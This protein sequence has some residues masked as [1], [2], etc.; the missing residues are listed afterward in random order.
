M[1]PI[2]EY[3]QLF[4]WF[5]AVLL[6]WGYVSCTICLGLLMLCVLSWHY[7]RVY[8]LR[9]KHVHMVKEMKDRYN[10]E[11]EQVK[12]RQAGLDMYDLMGYNLAEALVVQ[13]EIELKP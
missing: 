5:G 9:Q 11:H 3:I 13:N 7:V 10:L 2:F 6:K 4:V 1:S 12:L 8:A